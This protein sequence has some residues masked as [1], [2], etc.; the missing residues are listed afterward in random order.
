ME[1]GTVSDRA[2]LSRE[3]RLLSICDRIDVR[4]TGGRAGSP[5]EVAVQ[6]AK[7]CLSG[8]AVKP[9]AARARGARPM[10]RRD[11]RSGAKGFGSHGGGAVLNWA[12]PIQHVPQPG[13]P[14]VPIGTPPE[15][16][17]P[18]PGPGPEIP[19]QPPPTTPAPAPA[20]VPAGTPPELPPEIPPQP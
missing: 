6:R 16:P 15:I 14:E 7:L 5:L 19:A 20:E 10:R 17:P 4:R 2:P 11:S 13:S 18:S 1:R 8:A 9:S 12:M 3:W